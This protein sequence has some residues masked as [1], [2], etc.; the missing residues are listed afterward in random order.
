[1][2]WTSASDSR[3]QA[4]PS[5]L[6]LN[7]AERRV[8]KGRQTGEKSWVAERIELN[9]FAPP[10]FI[11]FIERKLK[12]AGADTKV[13]PPQQVIAESAREQGRSA[14]QR[15]VRGELDRIMDLDTVVGELADSLFTENALDVVD[16]EKVQEALEKS[17]EQAW[18]DVVRQ[19][20]DAIAAKQMDT[21][22]QR[23]WKAIS[24]RSSSDE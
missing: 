13:V 10:D 15:I 3:K 20:V 16:P 9:A 24:E 4:I 8:F 14:V 11:A 19:K 21:I 6:E 12:A 5:G 7:D 18:D 1:M 23:V 22:K 2:S 17:R